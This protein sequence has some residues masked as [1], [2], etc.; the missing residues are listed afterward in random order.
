MVRDWQ[1]YGGWIWH[2]TDYGTDIG[3]HIWRIWYVICPKYV[4]KILNLGLAGTGGRSGI[5]TDIRCGIMDGTSSKWWTGSKDGFK[6]A[7]A[8][9]DRIFSFDKKNFY[10]NQ[11]TQ[12]LQTF[13][14]NFFAGP[15]LPKRNGRTSEKEGEEGEGEAPAPTQRKR[16][17]LHSEGKGADSAAE[18]AF[19]IVQNLTRPFTTT[20]AAG[21]TITVIVISMLQIRASF[22]S[23]QKPR[24]LI[25]FNHNYPCR[26]MLSCWCWGLI[27]GVR[28][29]SSFLETQSLMSSYMSTLTVIYAVPGILKFYEK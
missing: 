9:E 4:P 23:W 19:V 3:L 29:H 14:W 25:F 5:G 7:K 17:R 13:W 21:A 6:Q 27:G 26:C 12:F 18:S 8:E 10:K 22:H 28:L 1:G 15:S 24:A 16:I 2:G 11:E 20:Q